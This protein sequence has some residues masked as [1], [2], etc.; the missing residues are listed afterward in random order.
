MAVTNIHQEIVSH[1][2]DRR[3]EEEK[4][5]YNL[6]YVKLFWWAEAGGWQFKVCLSYRVQGQAWSTV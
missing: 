1:A 6:T 5:K 2:M 4:K 3:A